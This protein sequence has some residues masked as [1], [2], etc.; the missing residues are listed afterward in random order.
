M[1]RF[2]FA[3]VL[4]AGSSFAQNTSIQ[5]DA[6][7][8]GS[9][10]FYGSGTH[11]VGSSATPAD[12]VYAQD[13]TVSDD[14]AV[15]DDASVSGDL[16]VTGAVTATGAISATVSVT[17][18]SLFITPAA[19]PRTTSGTSAGEL[20]FTNGSPGGTQSANTLYAFDGTS[21]QAAW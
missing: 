13:I 1:A 7:V 15:T 5:G 16:S 11:E 3:L 8:A 9:I 19:A 14:L 17:T 21:W 10:R 6:V 18:P 2:I 20:W 4:L 12:A